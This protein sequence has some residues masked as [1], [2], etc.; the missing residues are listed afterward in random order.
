MFTGNSM[1]TRGKRRADSRCEKT[2]HTG[3]LT[4][5]RELT[6]DTTTDP[7]KVQLDNPWVL[8]GFLIGI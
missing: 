1:K 2:Q 3:L 8:L 7:I 6:T 4:P 5:D